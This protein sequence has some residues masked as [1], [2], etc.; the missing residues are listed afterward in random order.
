M[1]LL[2]RKKYILANPKLTNTLDDRRTLVNFGLARICFFLFK[3]PIFLLKKA[4]QPMKE[5]A[6]YVNSKYASGILAININAH[7]SPRSLWSK[8]GGSIFFTVSQN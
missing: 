2:K 5:S 6:M 8:S 7:A 1:G 3:R 4:F